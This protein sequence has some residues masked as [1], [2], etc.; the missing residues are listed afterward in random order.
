MR[1]LWQMFTDSLD[2]LERNFLISHVSGRPYCS[3]CLRP[4]SVPFVIS[5]EGFF[6]FPKRTLLYLVDAEVL[7]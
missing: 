2:G 6:L 1:C 5:M 3:G 7:D 4:A